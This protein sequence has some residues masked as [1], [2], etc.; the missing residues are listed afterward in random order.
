[1]RLQGDW[2]SDGALPIFNRCGAS[3]IRFAAPVYAGGA[4]S[5]SASS[6]RT[7]R[8]ELEIRQLCSARSSIVRAFVTSD[9]AGTVRVAKVAWREIGRASCREEGRARGW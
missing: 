5:T 7:P 6:V 9:P 4:V 1:T 3:P 2:S 8:N